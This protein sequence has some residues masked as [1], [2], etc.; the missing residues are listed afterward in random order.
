VGTGYN[1]IGLDFGYR[2]YGVGLGGVNHCSLH[3]RLAKFCGL[4]IRGKY[5]AVIG[6][7]TRF[8]NE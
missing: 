2:M 3:C 6:R 5:G 1:G 4:M 8:F 7:E